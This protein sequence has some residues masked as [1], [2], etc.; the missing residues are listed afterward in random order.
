LLLDPGT[1]S[2]GKNYRADASVYV[3][4][5]TLAQMVAGK[6][7]PAKALLQKKMILKG[8]PIAIIKFRPSLITQKPKL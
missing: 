7:K 8:N 1:L 2:V 3:S 4:D 5:D 6:L